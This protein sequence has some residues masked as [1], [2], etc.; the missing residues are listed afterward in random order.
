MKTVKIEVEGIWTIL[1]EQVATDHMTIEETQVRAKTKEEALSI[2]NRH[3]AD[4]KWTYK[5]KIEDVRFLHAMK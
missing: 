3:I 1:H 2:F 4:G 5:A